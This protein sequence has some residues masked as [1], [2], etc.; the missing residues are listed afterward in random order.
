MVTPM[1]EPRTRSRWPFTALRVTATTL[2]ALAALQAF[3][4]GSF[5]NGQYA[6][7]TAHSTVAIVMIVV[8]VVQAVFAV[9]ARRAG[10]PRQLLIPGLVMPFV[11]AAQA[12]L[13]DA[14]IIGVHVLLGSLMVFGLFQLAVT[15]W[16][17]RSEPSAVDTAAV[18]S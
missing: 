2:A 18:P 16:R 8:S 9:F 3:F 12:A 1:T 15:V 7:L 4:A 17:R 6:M 10:A 13:G 5:L 14:R 11:I